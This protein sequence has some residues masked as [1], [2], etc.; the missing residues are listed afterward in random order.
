MC[1]DL[2]KPI[3]TVLHWA[4]NIKQH[5]QRKYVCKALGGSGAKLAYVVVDKATC[6]NTP[7]GMGDHVKMYNYALRRLLERISWF[8]HGRNRDVH[9]A[10]A[11]VRNFKYPAL[12]SYLS[13]LKTLRTTI[14]W[15]RLVS[16]KIKD[17][18][19]RQLLQ[20]ADIAAGALSAAIVADRF[21]AVEYGY[22]EE[23]Q[24]M[25][26]RHTPGKVTTYGLHVV[27]DDRLLRSQPWWGAFP[28]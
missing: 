6:S 19:Q 13:L 1:A 26:Y 16:I 14:R 20:F 17:T 5:S 18:T 7:D 22:L 27:T 28:N 21:G 11:H 25:I 15:N 8:A 23:L 3:D 12:D 4:Q 10:I 9:L 24:G 2:D